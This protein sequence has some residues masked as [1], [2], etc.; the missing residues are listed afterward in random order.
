MGLSLKV[1]AQF[2]SHDEFYEWD[3][4]TNTFETTPSLKGKRFRIDRFTT[5]YHRP[6]RRSYIRF[7][8][9]RFPKHGVVRRGSSGETYLVSQS[10]NVDIEAG[11]LKYEQI[12]M[13]HLATAPSGGVGTFVPVV[14]TGAG[15]D[16]GY[17]DLTTEYNAYVDIEIQSATTTEESI[18]AVTPKFILNHSTNI[19]PMEGD[20]FYFN[21][22]SFIVSIPYIDGGLSVARVIETPPKYENFTYRKQS[23]A[24]SYDPSTGIITNGVTE[25]GFSGII[26]RNQNSDAQLRQTFPNML[27]L[28]VYERHVG[29]VFETGNTVVYGSEEYYINSVTD[30]REDKQYKLELSR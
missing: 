19:S 16:L 9:D 29:F 26:G 2:A 7:L 17:V 24:G 28:Y 21:G 3:A 14:T 6:T 8:S 5:I 27:E 18:D 10:L 20:I 25:L 4:V 11:K 30:R 13:S 15:E 1:A 22:R 12:R 23:G